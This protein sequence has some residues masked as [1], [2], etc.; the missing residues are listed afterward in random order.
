MNRQEHDDLVFFA[1]KMNKK[2]ATITDCQNRIT[3]I[4]INIRNNESKTKHEIGKIISDTDIM[5]H[6]IANLQ[7]DEQN[8]RKMND[9]NTEAIRDLRVRMDKLKDLASHFINQH[10]A[11]V[12][13]TV[14]KLRREIKEAHDIGKQKH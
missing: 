7:K 10:K 6:Q 12:D 4:E 8:L 5:K 13:D 1:N 3:Q 9:L 2:V 11:E 14:F